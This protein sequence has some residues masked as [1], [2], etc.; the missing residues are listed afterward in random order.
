MVETN[1]L[2]LLDKIEMV[3]QL[4]QLLLFKKLF[5]RICTCSEERYKVRKT[6]SLPPTDPEDNHQE[7]MRRCKENINC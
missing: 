7:A 4:E 6:V 3:N 5:K 1:I 2:V